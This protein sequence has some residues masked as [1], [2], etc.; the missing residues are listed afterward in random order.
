V[1]A[2]PRFTPVEVVLKIGFLE[3]ESGRTAVDNTEVTV[4]VAFAARRY[5]ECFSK[6]I[7]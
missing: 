1:S 7:S 6:G 4:T 5:G 3:R 2:L